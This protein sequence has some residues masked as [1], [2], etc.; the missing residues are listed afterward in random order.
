M[1][2]FQ[3]LDNIYKKLSDIDRLT[4]QQETKKTLHTIGNIIS[5]SI[6][7][8]FENQTSPWGDPWQELNPKTKKYKQKKN[9]SNKILRSDGNLEDNWIQTITD[10]TLTI[11]N[12]ASVND[13][14]YGN[15]HQWG[16]KKTPPRPF[17]PVDDKGT[18][19]PK[20]LKKIDD[21]LDYKLEEVLK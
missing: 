3:G 19:E 13:Y 1:I 6:Q 15:A 11:S 18:I 14:H 5:N 21:Y 17:I 2:E 9:K 16:T 12:N 10:D 8:S 4:S 7:E 20:V